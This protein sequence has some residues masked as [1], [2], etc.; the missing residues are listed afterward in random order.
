MREIKFRAW[1]SKRKEMIHF[2]EP[3]ICIEYSNLTFDCREYQGICE[4]PEG[5]EHIEDL[6]LMQYTGLKDK[7]GKEI[8]EGDILKITNKPDWP[9][10]FC[11]VRFDLG[12]FFI[13]MDGTSNPLGLDL[14]GFVHE[15]WDYQVVGNIYENPELL[16]GRF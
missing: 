4:L 13:E 11:E 16:K 10:A 8:Y 1:S 2:E 5:A 15:G 6:E 9:S 7:N 14:R 12:Y 3:E